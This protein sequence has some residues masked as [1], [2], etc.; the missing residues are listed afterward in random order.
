LQIY[1]LNKQYFKL[2]RLKFN[3]IKNYFCGPIIN[4]GF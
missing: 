3:H 4:H 2:K 1:K